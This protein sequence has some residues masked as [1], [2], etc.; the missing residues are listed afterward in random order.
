MSRLPRTIAFALSISVVLA[1]APFALGTSA[2][3]AP[4]GW[5][6]IATGGLGNPQHAAMFPLIEFQGKAYS[7]VPN[8][9]GG[10]GPS[11]PAPVWAYDGQHW[12]KAAPEGFGDINN[13]AI[14]PGAVFQGQLYLGTSNYNAGG[15]LWRTPD[16]THWERVSQ[17][18]ISIPSNNNCWP[19]GVQDGK[20]II[21][22]DN[23]QT[24][25]QAFTY[26]GSNFVRANIDGFGEDAVALGMGATLNG[27][28]NVII[29]RRSPGTGVQEPVIPLAYA[30]GTTWEAT[31]A[32][33]FGDTANLAS[34]VLSRDGDFLYTG[35]INDNGGQ[36]WR[37]DGTNWS[38]INLGSIS[39]PRTTWCWLHP[40]RATC[41][42]GPASSHPTAL[43]PDL[44]SFIARSRTGASRP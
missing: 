29:Q 21:A 17:A 14:S 3:A 37:F 40:S 6:R 10:G 5:T 27:R 24:G 13:S 39:T 2:V 1:L 43:R 42:S 26:D 33:G 28:V 15:Q 4:S 19:L 38:Q 36:A 11:I 31:G 30:G 32:K 18:V 8:T 35:T 34:Y 12:A 25:V 9:S 7:F 41:S 44:A 22:F 16:G 20:L 23:Y